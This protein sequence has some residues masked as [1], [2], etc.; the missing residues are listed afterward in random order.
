MSTHL[1]LVVGAYL[2]GSI[3]FGLLIARASGGVD[4]RRVGS[5][6]IG[7]TNVLRAAGKGAAV[8]T[9]M[10]DTLK[11]WAPVALTSSLGES[12]ALVAAV[13]L[14][15]FLGHLY[16]IFLGLRGGKG[17]ATALGVLLALSVKAALL[18]A[19]AWLL[20]AAL[21]RYSSV[22]ALVA[23]ATAPVLVW[24]VD[25]RPSSVALTVVLAA[26]IVFRHRENFRRLMTGEESRIGQRV[27]LPGADASRR[28]DP[29]L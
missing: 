14:A 11:G 25:G 26:F 9:L 2:L 17:V 13:G 6:N 24:L 4:I 28:D 18:I 19:A 27:N 29:K 8:L 10:F 20:T 23:C 7:A 21:I 12:G 3:P 22:A 15:A 16:P 1:W 5:G